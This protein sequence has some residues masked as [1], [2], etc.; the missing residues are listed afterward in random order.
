[1][2]KQRNNAKAKKAGDAK[3]TKPEPVVENIEDDE[4]EEEEEEP[5]D[6]Y[7]GQA[8]KRAMDESISEVC[9]PV[10]GSNSHCR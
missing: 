3:V 4:E 6:V 1:M 10:A 2:A 9:A 7:D 5:I 8:V